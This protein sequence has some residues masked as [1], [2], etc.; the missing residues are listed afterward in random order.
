MTTRTPSTSPTHNE[1]PQQAD[2]ALDDGDLANVSAPRHDDD[3]GDLVHLSDRVEDSSVIVN[4]IIEKHREEISEDSFLCMLTLHQLFIA[5]L[6]RIDIDIERAYAQRAN[7]L[8]K[9]RDQ[10]SDMLLLWHRDNTPIQTSFFGTTKH[11]MG[12]KNDKS[13]IKRFAECKTIDVS[14]VFSYLIC[15]FRGR[16]TDGLLRLNSIVAYN[17]F[18]QR[19]FDAYVGKNRQSSYSV[20][21]SSSNFSGTTTH[22]T[23]IKCSSWAN[24]VAPVRNVP[25]IVN[26]VHKLETVMTR[27]YDI[28]Q[29]IALLDEQLQL[30]DDQ[31]YRTEE[32]QYAIVQKLKSTVSDE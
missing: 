16:T 1:K 17:K 5:F 8:T 12:G 32:E 28:Q 10:V 18:G 30:L 22:C 6:L 13:C 21:S 26:L 9:L 27:K 19:V 24:A 25:M 29:Q 23:T 11:A 20:A 2:L 31:L 4:Q 15:A 14:N 3:D 7:A